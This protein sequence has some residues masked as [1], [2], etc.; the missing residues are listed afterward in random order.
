M[1]YANGGFLNLR[2]EGDLITIT[3][4]LPDNCKDRTRGLIGQWDGDA[5]NDLLMRNGTLLSPNVTDREKETVAE[6]WRIT[7]DESLMVYDTGNYSTYK[8]DLIS[9]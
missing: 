5:S 3:I 2:A 4:S 9:Y 6:S 7:E 1:A 8:W